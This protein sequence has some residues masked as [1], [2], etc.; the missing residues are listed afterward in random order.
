MLLF[1]YLH[2]WR[3]S[4]ASHCHSYRPCSS[5]ISRGSC[6]TTPVDHKNSAKKSVTPWNWRYPKVGRDNLWMFKLHA[7]GA[8]NLWDYQDVLN[9]RSACIQIDGL[10]PYKVSKL[11]GC[12]QVHSRSNVV[13]L[14]LTH[15]IHCVEFNY[16]SVVTGEHFTTCTKE[17]LCSQPATFVFTDCLISLASL[18]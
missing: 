8:T 4:N 18:D 17:C 9:T 6:S 7:C 15:L 14:S 13:S 2:R 1:L 3:H 10:R 12:L 5:F 16:N 11:C